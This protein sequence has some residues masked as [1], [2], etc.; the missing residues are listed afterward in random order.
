M[1][2]NRPDYCGVKRE[3]NR[4]LLNKEREKM[5]YFKYGSTK[6]EYLELGKEI[7]SILDVIDALMQ[8][9]YGHGTIITS[10]YREDK[11]SPHYYYRAADVSTKGLGHGKCRYIQNI[12]NIIFP[13]DR[14]HYQ[15]VI[16]HDAGSGWHFHVQVKP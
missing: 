6:E 5:L 11:N 9:L 3:I 1:S 15:T 16:Y 7:R 13:Y 4:K 2:F 10:V 12:I 8:A 14:E